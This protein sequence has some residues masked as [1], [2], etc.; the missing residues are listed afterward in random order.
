MFVIWNH[1]QRKYVAEPGLK[2]SFT[3]SLAKARKFP[4]E[5]AAKAD[6]CGDESVREDRT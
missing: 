6:C 4:T 1:T 3:R 2:S 5:A